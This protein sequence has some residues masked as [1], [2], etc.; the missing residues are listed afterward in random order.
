MPLAHYPR[1]LE[2]VLIVMIAD[3]APGSIERFRAY[4]DQV[5]AL[6]ERH[7]GRLERRLRT[8]D[9]TSE[10][11]LLAFDSQEGYEA[12]LEDPG[13]VTARAT[14]AGTEITQRI[15]EVSEVPASAS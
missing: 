9:G 7:G 3:I 13:R 4:E 14:L 12:Y 11:H 5:L 15:L 6:L 8:A 10:V 2:A 1:S